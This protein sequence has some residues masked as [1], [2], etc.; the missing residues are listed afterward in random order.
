[1]YTCRPLTLL[2]AIILTGLTIFVN[3]GAVYANPK[4]TAEPEPPWAEREPGSE[5]L[6]PPNIR[7]VSPSTEWIFHKTPDNQHP[8]E[9][10]QQLIWLMNRARSNP[11]AEGIWLATLYDQYISY[12]PG[13]AGAGLDADLCY[14]AAAVDYWRVDR[15]QLKSE[16]ASYDTKPPAA[17]DV[18]L[19]R[20]AKSHSDYLI[21]IDGQGHS[22]QFD[23][24]D[25]EGFEFIR[26]RG[27]VFS[28]SLSAV[29]GHAGFNIDWGNDGGDGTGM[30]PSRGHRLAIMSI[31]GDY[32]N[33]GIAAVSETT[34]GKS[35]GPLV[36]T[37]NYCRANAGM[38][39]HYNRFLV[40]TVWSDRDNDRLY[41]PGEGIGNV[42]VMP[43]QGSY[44][45]LTS[46]SGGYALPIITAGRY[47]V[48]F[49]GGSLS[50]NVIKTVMVGDDSVLLD[51]VDGSSSA[52]SLGEHSGSNDSNH[53]DGDGGSGG[54][55]ISGTAT[56]IPIPSSFK[57]TIFITVLSALVGLASIRPK[58]SAI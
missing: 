9:N 48:T 14:V 13:C 55:F 34:R 23:R 29:Y 45:A 18:R 52:S 36:I 47:D 2:A 35:V 19:Y 31:D 43:D 33:V 11:T 56:H 46:D 40:G 58:S 41:D 44:Y 6:L 15:E 32:T 10:E 38:S 26:A 57:F 20:A 17:F 25:D 27:N 39:D 30:Q 28:Y 37:G 51:L 1:M 53:N 4:H 8:D 54:C 24:I 49:S 16:F 21:D 22:G 7:T 42:T 50:E 3:P 12:S 5:D